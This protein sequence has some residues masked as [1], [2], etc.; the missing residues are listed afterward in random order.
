[1]DPPAR[2]RG[3]PKSTARLVALDRVHE[4]DVPFL[5]E[6]SEACRST[7]VLGSDLNDQAEVGRDEP[8][9][10][11]GG[12]GPCELKRDRMFFIAIHDAMPSHVP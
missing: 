7:A 11:S 3:E 6:I 4:P 12:A 8:S 10:E 1:M 2:I 9:S 5:H